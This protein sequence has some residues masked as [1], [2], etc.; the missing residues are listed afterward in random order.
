[1]IFVTYSHMLD[2]PSFLITVVILHSISSLLVTLK[3]A[4]GL[5]L[6][7]PAPLRPRV[8]F[9]QTS[10]EGLLRLRSVRLKTSRLLAMAPSQW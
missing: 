9:T 2:V 5:S 1:M 3:F 7:E 6:L 10:R 8:L 4:A